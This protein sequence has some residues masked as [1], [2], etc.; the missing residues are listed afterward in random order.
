M[1]QRKRTET[2][3][4]GDI[5]EEIYRAGDREGGGHERQRNRARKIRGRGGEGGQ[6]QQRGRKTCREE[7]RQ[8]GRKTWRRARQKGQ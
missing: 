7:K 2:Y 4:T 3:V 5:Q 6:R 1:G 8:R